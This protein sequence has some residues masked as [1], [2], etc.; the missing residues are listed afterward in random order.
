MISEQKKVCEEVCFHD[1][2]AEKIK[3]NRKVA[4][5]YYNYDSPASYVAN[6]L[7][8]LKRKLLATLGDPKNKRVLV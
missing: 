2:I 4:Q 8:R 7:P 3:I 5:K 6:R 1:H